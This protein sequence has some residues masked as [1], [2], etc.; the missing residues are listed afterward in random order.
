[1]RPPNLSHHAT[2]NPDPRAP[3]QHLQEGIRHRNDAIVRIS[4]LILGFP[5]G[6]PRR[7]EGGNLDALQGGMATPSGA[8][9]SVPDQPAGI[10]PVPRNH[11]PKESK[12]QQPSEEAHT[13]TRTG[14]ASAGRHS[15]QTTLQPTELRPRRA[16][17]QSPDP[18]PPGPDL[19]RKPAVA[20]GAAALPPATCTHP[21]PER[22][23]TSQPPPPPPAS[24]RVLC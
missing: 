7:V 11:I 23:I 1:M 22:G 24:T 21:A 18:G 19:A 9:A 10:S 14:A 5:P 12:A 3:R 20:A 4:E 6:T 16:L 2:C 8:A 15:K 13:R 17:K